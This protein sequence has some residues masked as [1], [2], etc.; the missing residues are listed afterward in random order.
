MD[1][2]RPQPS[3]ADSQHITMDMDERTWEEK[4]KGLWSATP[5]YVLEKHLLSRAPT[6]ARNLYETIL[7]QGNYHGGIATFESWKE[8]AQ[9]ADIPLGNISRAIDWLVA[10][11]L[12]ARFGPN[13]FRIVRSEVLSTQLSIHRTA[14]KEEARVKR[15]K[16]WSSKR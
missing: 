9:L 10:K 16:A 3:P 7:V 8:I 13:C 14:F 11:Y 4:N 1:R 2:D 6:Y 12:V 5:N 15:F